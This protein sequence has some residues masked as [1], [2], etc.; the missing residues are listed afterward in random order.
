MVEESRRGDNAAAADIGADHGYLACALVESGVCERAVASDI[1]PLPL[2][3]AG[4][5]V[6]ACGL[7]D[8]ITLVLSDGLRSVPL[9]G[10]THI[11]CAGMGGELIARII[12]EC[13]RARDCTLILQ[14]MTKADRLRKA[15]F[16]NGFY[17]SRETACRDGRFV[18][19]VICAEYSPEK[20]DY[21]CDEIYLYAGR[22]DPRELDG[23][24]YLKRTAAKLEKAAAGIERGENAE[25]KQALYLRAAARKLYEK[26]GEGI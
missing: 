23:G 12:L 3:S 9:D 20:I 24:L 6:E 26:A 1:N 18:Y 13:E 4:K 7:N 15:L 5:T 25:E 22:I 16:E 8:K 11:I 2:E 14:P 17:I 10:I 21:A 19:P